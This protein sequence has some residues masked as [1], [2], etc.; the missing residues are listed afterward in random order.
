MI[1]FGTLVPH[2]PIIVSGIGQTA[3]LNQ[4]K[5]T[6]MAMG[7]IN[8]L[9]VEDP[10]E[11]LVVFTPH[12]TVFSDAIVVYEDETLRGDL[13]RFGLNRTWEWKNDLE[14]VERIIDFSQADNLPVLKLD[15]NLAKRYRPQG[16]LDHGVLVPL[17]FFSP[18]WASRT[19]LVIIPLSYLPLEDLYRFGT[20]IKRAVGQLERK[21]A[22]IASGD[23]SHCLKPG[24]PA[25]FDPR[26]AEF[27]HK[28][29]EL[30][31][32]A[33]VKELFEID[34]LLLEKAAEC[35]FRSII[36]LMG[37][38]DQNE[39]SVKVH[40]YQGPFG[41][42][43]GVVSFKPTGETRESL[44]E[45]LFENRNKLVAARRQKES[46]L[47]SYARQTVEAYVKGETLADPEGLEDF[48]DQQAGAFVSIK[49]H[50]QLRGCIG[51]TEPTQKNV[52]VE[53]QQNAISAS[54]RD[55]RFDPVI[56]DELDD[57]V[58][59]VDILK[60]AAPISDL[61]ELDPQRYGVIVSQGHRR[62]LLLPN[63]EGIETAEEQV[64][65]AM[66]KAG[67]PEGADVELE[68]FEV[69]RYY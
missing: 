17:S 10:P 68:R 18:E 13:T 16:A 26:G 30:L 5:E 37:T 65:I 39:F 6:V 47:V 62:G 40:S 52:V 3:D 14:L 53:I 43:Y 11:T 4:V 57:L 50:G 58:Y 56:G 67:I 34:P 54:T 35:G 12:G 28:L 8:R 1:T 59:S 55:P 31:K 23:L 42:G 45:E 22:I 33:V 51:T 9:L 49:K 63:L 41:V 2:P 29:M 46:P 66:R 7:E 48:Q 24:A 60:P 38:L 15:Q 20:I 61:T 27:D 21:V 64:A 44:L 69:V 19:K 25:G 32:E 36:M